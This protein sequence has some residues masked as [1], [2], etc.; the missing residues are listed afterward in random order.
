MGAFMKVTARE[1]IILTAVIICCL[2]EVASASNIV[3]SEANQQHVLELDV[4]GL[5]NVTSLNNAVIPRLFHYITCGSSGGGHIN[6]LTANQ[7]NNIASCQNAVENGRFDVMTWNCAQLDVIFTQ[8]KLR[9]T[10]A[11]F[12]SEQ[13]FYA[14]VFSVMYLHGGTYID[15]NVGCRHDVTALYQQMAYHS[16]AAAALAYSE[17]I[18]VFPKLI[19]SK[20]RHPLMRQLVQHVSGTNRDRLSALF[21]SGHVQRY[22]NAVFLTYVHCRT[23]EPPW[24]CRHQSTASFVYLP[25]TQEARDIYFSNLTDD[26]T[27]TLAHRV[28]LYAPLRCDFLM[29]VL[30]VVLVGLIVVVIVRECE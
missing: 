20:Q 27:V 28:L 24:T 10:A 3:H 19:V 13:R 26:V 7:R 22:V 11:T 9:D 30:F 2:I 5:R 6:S 21:D 4:I 16:N 23:E 18:G 1:C 17:Y 15:V 8:L 12:S 29:T 14:A 25:R